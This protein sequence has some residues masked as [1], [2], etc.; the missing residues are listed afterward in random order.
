M[1][2]FLAVCLIGLTACSNTSSAL[3]TSIPTTSTSIVADLLSRCSTT[4]S[5]PPQ[6]TEYDAWDANRVVTTDIDIDGQ[7]NKIISGYL[8]DEQDFNYK[9][10]FSTVGVDGWGFQFI[11]KFNPQSEFEWIRCLRESSLYHWYK[12]PV[13]D[14]DSNGF[15][16]VCDSTLERWTTTGELVWSSET[17][18]WDSEDSSDATRNCA[19]SSDGF[20]VVTGVDETYFVSAEGKNLWRK[21]LGFYSAA[22]FLEDGNIALASNSSV[23]VINRRGEVQWQHSRNQRNDIGPDGLI[24]GWTNSHPT[25]Q[26]GLSVD[27]TGI[28][29]ATSLNKKADFDGSEKVKNIGPRW[30]QEA[31]VAR[32]SFTGQLNWATKIQL[33]NVSNGS[34]QYQEIFDLKI[35]DNGNIYVYGGGTRDRVAEPTK[36]FLLKF[37]PSGEQLRLLWLDEYINFIHNLGRYMDIDNR[38]RVYGTMESLKL[39]PFLWSR[40]L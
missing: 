13:V 8:S 1:L 17:L 19:T 39:A 33:P 6:Q 22:E 30:I 10:S 27:D 29:I 7:G 5:T 14:T 40:D 4:R 36:L 20:T 9:D 32:Y 23:M 2:R 24:D 35:G 26:T 38:G 16:Y 3:T 12:G 15:I 28:V 37:S 11:A 34:G 18:R 31:V 21:D 25:D